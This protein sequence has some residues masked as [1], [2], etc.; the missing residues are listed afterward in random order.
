MEDLII[1]RR[2]TLLNPRTRN[3]ESKT[4]KNKLLEK[5][6]FRKRER[7]RAKAHTSLFLHPFL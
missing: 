3:K 5:N 7:E 2:K 4:P 6:G 1:R